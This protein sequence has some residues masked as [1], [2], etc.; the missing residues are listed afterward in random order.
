MFCDDKSYFEYGVKVEHCI[1]STGF[2][3]RQF[4]GLNCFSEFMN[5]GCK[6]IK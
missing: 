5:L 4:E 2:A 3:E 6:E 1:V